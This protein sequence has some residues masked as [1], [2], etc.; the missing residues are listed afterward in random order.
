[1]LGLPVQVIV[2]IT[3]KPLMLDKIRA[4]G[5]KVTVHGENWNAADELARKMVAEDD[6]AAY[7]SP[8]D[9]PLLWEGH[10]TIIDEIAKSGIKPG[11]SP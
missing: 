3:T 4:Q 1:M 7:I 2:P 6:K 8:Y 11:R 5:A 9:H 10:S